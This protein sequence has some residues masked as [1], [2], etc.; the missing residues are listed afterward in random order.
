M[1]KKDE[2][3]KMSTALKVIGGCF[4]AIGFIAGIYFLIELSVNIS[5]GYGFLA[6]LLC[7]SAGVVLLVLCCVLGGMLETLCK[8]N[9]NLE[10][11]K[12]KYLK[13]E[14]NIDLVSENNEKSQN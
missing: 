8:V 12:N 1:L 6:M 9:N 7:L 14:E 10:E 4:L 13:L 5:F 3:Y 2:N 11:I